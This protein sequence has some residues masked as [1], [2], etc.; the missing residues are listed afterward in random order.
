MRLGQ[1][2]LGRHDFF[3]GLSYDV[4]SLLSA[5][6]L[7]L[8]ANQLAIERNYI[9][10][11]LY[12]VLRG[13]IRINR[14]SDFNDGYLTKIVTESQLFGNVY[15]SDNNTREFVEVFDNK[16]LV[17]VAEPETVRNWLHKYPQLFNNYL[18]LLQQ[19]DDN[20]C[21]RMS[22]LINRSAEERVLSFIYNWANKY[23]SKTGGVLIVRNPF[24]HA[25]LGEYLFCSRQFISK[26]F[27]TLKRQ[28]A[29]KYD[30]FT[31]Q[32]NLGNKVWKE[33]QK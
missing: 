24:T 20:S 33:F 15:L 16:L 11:K 19:E 27:T 18:K 22:G 21:D 1:S 13:T 14:Y 7:V 5:D 3:K 2:L 26:C 28:S 12:F 31:Y 10:R 9:E 25:Q 30:R 29:L 23:G 8:D 6:L 17:A 32:V 4:V